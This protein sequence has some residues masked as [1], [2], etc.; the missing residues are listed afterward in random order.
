VRAFSRDPRH[1][2][3]AHQVYFYLWRDY[4]REGREAVFISSSRF[5]FL[6]FVANGS[7]QPKDISALRSIDFRIDCLSFSSTASA[8]DG[9]LH[10]PLSSNEPDHRSRP[11]TRRRYRSSLRVCFLVLPPSP[12]PLQ[13]LSFRHSDSIPWPMCVR[14]EFLSPFTLSPLVLDLSPRRKE[15]GLSRDNAG[16]PTAANNCRIVVNVAQ[17]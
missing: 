6:S 16:P 15:Q 7:D 4:L 5:L 2:P 8:A 1:I 3:I 14:R 12:L 17:R 10:L 13:K 11:P 9:L